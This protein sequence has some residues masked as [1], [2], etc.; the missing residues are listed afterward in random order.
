MKDPANRESMA[1]IYRL[2]EKYE[3]APLIH[4]ANEAT[5]YFKSALA[6]V[7]AIYTKYAGYAFAQQF[8]L[9]L[10]AAIEQNFKKVNP[11]PL[12]ED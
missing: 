7:D 8:A 4:S 2:V 1:A 5:S 11:G 6:D 10:Y 12:L 9:A 3:T